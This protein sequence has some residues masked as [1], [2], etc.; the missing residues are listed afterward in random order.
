M[1][2]QELSNAFNFAGVE[3]Q[4]ET[5]ATVIDKKGHVRFNE[6]L[7][8]YNAIFND[9][10]LLEKRMDYQKRRLIKNLIDSGFRLNQYS[11]EGGRQ[12]FSQMSDD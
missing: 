7:A 6:T 4:N 3:Y 12:L 5:T 2:Q 1:T 10:S 9:S 11:T 8:N